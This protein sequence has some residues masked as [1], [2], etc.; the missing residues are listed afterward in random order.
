MAAPLATLTL[1]GLEV[2][3]RHDTDMWN[4]GWATYLG[5]RDT[6]ASI[7]MLGRF[8]VRLQAPLEE[9]GTAADAALVATGYEN[10]CD[11]IGSFNVRPIA[12]HDVWSEHAYGTAFD[13]DFAGDNPLSPRH[14]LSVDRNP[15][16]GNGNG[17]L[18]GDPRFGVACQITE[19]QVRALEAIRT[20]NGMRVWGWLGWFPRGDTMHFGPRCRPEDLETGIDWTT[21]AGQGGEDV[22]FAIAVLKR[23]PDAFWPELQRRTGVPGGDPMYWSQRGSR[24]AGRATE[25]EWRDEVETIFAAAI[26]VGVLQPE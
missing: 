22:E 6:L 15:D 17:L 26:E 19:T 25:K 13:L 2:T 9:A 21:V 11:F 23:Q 14:G 3:H 18:P 12:E 5:R 10:P 8:P 24:D 4:L 20:K 1:D 16:L 7:T